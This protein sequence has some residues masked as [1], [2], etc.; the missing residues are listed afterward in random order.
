[1]TTTT[2]TALAGAPLRARRSP[3]AVPRGVP[4]WLWLFGVTVQR[5]GTPAADG[6]TAWVVSA[7]GGT[8]GFA[9]VLFDTTEQDRSDITREDRT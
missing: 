5:L 3:R 1:M 6:T 7:G 8:S 2:T 9:A 4:R